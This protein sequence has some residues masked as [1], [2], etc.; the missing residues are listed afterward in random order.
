MEM[1]IRSKGLVAVTILAMVLLGIS[2]WLLQIKISSNLRSDVGDSLFTV[3]TT[4]QQAV[5]SWN[6]EHM[7]AALVWAETTDVHKFTQQ[8]LATSLTTQ[9]LVK[10]SAQEKLRVLFK[11]VIKAKGYQGFFIIGPDKTN[12]A[13]SRDENV[14]IKSLLA[15]QKKFEETIWSGQ[16]ALSL[17]LHSDVPLPDENGQLRSGV[18]TMFV[19]APVRDET[20]TVIA[21][22]CFRINPA[23][24]FTTIF[25]R[26]RIGKSGETYAFDG[27]GYLISESR[28]DE[29]L[30]AIGMITPSERGILNIIVSDPGVNL[31]QG[32]MNAIPVEKRSLT[33]MADSAVTGK[34]GA[35]LDGYRGYRGVPVVGAWLWDDALGLG[36]TTEIE[37]DE[38][39]ETLY[40]TRYTLIVATV[41]AITLLFVL[42]LIFLKSRNKIE[43]SEKQYRRLIETSGQGVWVIDADSI[44]TFVNKKM[45]EMLGYNIDEMTG[46]SMYEFMGSEEKAQAADNVKRRKSGI[47]EQHE[48]LLSSKDGTGLWVE[49]NTNPIIDDDGRYKGA[50]AMSTDITER[51]KMEEALRASKE[52]M[53]AIIENAVDGIITA[54][55][56]GIIESANPAVSSIFGYTQE[57][58]VGESINIL[59]AEGEH[60]KHDNYIKRYIDTGEKKIIGVGSREVMAAREDGSCFPIGIAIGEMKSKGHKKFI[61][62][63]RDI[64]EQKKYE[65]AL[66]QSE[67]RLKEAQE[68]AHVGHWDL[69]LIED[70]LVWSDE[71]FR[72]FGVEPQSFGESLEAFM[73]AIH[74]DDKEMVQMAYSDSIK[75]HAPYNITHKVVRPDGEVR[76]VHEI[77]KTVYDSMGKALRSIGT[78]Q[79]IT[80]RIK[81]EQEKVQLQH[82]LQQS[83]KMQSI[84]HLTG[85]VAHDFNNILVSILGYTDL[86]LTRYVPDKDSKLAEYLLEV[87]KAGVRAQ[88]LIAQMLAFSRGSIS[89]PEKIMMEPLLKDVIKMLRSTLPASIEIKYVIDADL[90]AIKADSVRL[91]QVVTN[92]CINARDAMEGSGRLDIVFHKTSLDQ[93]HC[94]SCH[95]VVSGDYLELSIEDSG[96]GISE[97]LLPNIFDPFFSTKD[98]GK[99][100]GMGLSVVHGIV[101]EYG[102]HILVNSEPGVGTNFRILLPILNGEEDI[103]E[104]IKEDVDAIN[105]ITKYNEGTVNSRILIVDDEISITGFLSELLESNG[106]QVIALNDP[107]EALDLY[108][109]DPMAMNLIVLDQTMPGMTGAQT[110]EKILGLR[111]DMPIILCTGFSEKMDE[112]QAR[113]IGVRAFLNKPFETGQLLGLID[114]LIEEDRS[115]LH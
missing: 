71:V 83:Q 2:S 10:S 21:I 102:G 107:Y 86:A 94:A 7:A 50:L 105:E 52:Q 9:D 93:S 43:E 114:T 51:K 99:G 11:P 22:F 104:E 89:S 28:F 26:G 115:K 64:S 106:Y 55:M 54:D 72:I 46:M 92:L 80:D 109:S 5:H 47:A 29:Q 40:A 75:D 34:A 91:H 17:P 61:A 32:N 68:I 44:T 23:K 87:N 45:A 35:D 36:I 33:R 84:G 69:D 63:I 70:K 49:M 1:I 6:N 41:I 14:G 39:Y 67:D 16:T 27:Q 81:S 13:S 76:F 96:S 108:E 110:A 42:S 60:L 31:L 8:L 53:Q 103:E 58:L 95:E 112:I 65:H 97:A 18:P 57:Q 38:A 74:P 59:M 113:K 66:K 85:G 20:D 111:P 78:V 101:H 24:E 25:Q 30:Q 100:Y 77:C 62:M 88:D 3:L 90:P 12:L 15:R 37:V 79:D 73:S 82:Q 56:S 98:V 48:F 4:T 19:G